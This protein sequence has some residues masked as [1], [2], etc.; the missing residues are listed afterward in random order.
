MRKLLFAFTVFTIQAGF[1][2]NQIGINQAIVDA[3]AVLEMNS[4]E[5]GFL[6]PQMTADS[7]SEIVSPAPGLLIYETSTLNFW[8]FNGARWIKIISN[9]SQIDGIGDEDSD[10][11]I[12]LDFI[13]NNDQIRFFSAGIQ[14]ARMNR[15]RF[16]ILNTGNS[17]FLGDS[18]G[19][20]DD[21]TSN[22][23]VLIGGSAGLESV[24]AKRNVGIGYQV[25]RE[26]VD[27]DDNI[28]IGN[29]ASRLAF[30]ARR[31]VAIGAKALLKNTISDQNIAIGFSAMELHA[32]RNNSVSIG[33]ESMQIDTNSQN[34]VALGT[35][36]LASI[37]SDNSNVAIGYQA[38][39]LN[40]GSNSVYLGCNSGSSSGSNNRLFVDNSFTTDPLLYGNFSSNNLTINGSMFVS[41]NI[42]YFGTL[43]DVSDRRL[44]TEIRKE[45]KTLSKLVNLNGYRYELRNDN[46]N[47]KEYGLIAQE[48][49]LEFPT[50]VRKIYSD[51]DY[52]GVSYVQFIPLIIEAEKEQYMQLQ[53]LESSHDALNIQIDNVENQLKVIMKKMALQTTQLTDL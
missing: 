4:A 7:K 32:T 38:G 15:K 21:L 42:S 11:R 17:V 37:L 16:D 2:Q 20:S 53:K 33:I 45:S 30:T 48:V 5:K 12:I 50:L 14:F 40:A 6:I 34:M 8:Y 27:D 9:N 23:N 44:K 25:L 19:Y 36:S 10:T 49:L 52:I 24:N 41:S 28:A 3:S 51:K 43:T 35:R 39:R 13:D 18:A 46:S 1:A 26:N 29:Y 47:R 22:Y 31:N